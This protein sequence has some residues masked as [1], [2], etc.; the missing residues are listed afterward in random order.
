MPRNLPHYTKCAPPG[1][2]RPMDTF[3]ILGLSLSSIII[4]GIGGTA[5]AMIM[6]ILGLA[7][8][9]GCALG[10]GFI[11]FAIYA[12]FAFKHWYYNERLLCIK[13]D[14]CV[15][16]TVVHDPTDATDGDR[17][18]DIVLAPFS[19]DEQV[20]W[21]KEVIEDKRIGGLSAP[22][23]SE[24][25]DPNKFKDF[26]SGAPPYNLT[27]SNLT[28]IYQTLVHEKI[29]DPSH[30]DRNFY[31]HYFRTEDPP[32]NDEN[33]ATSSAIPDD[34]YNPTGTSNPMFRYPSGGSDTINEVGDPY[35][36]LHCEMEGYRLGAWLDNVAVGLIAGGTTFTALC[37]LCEVIT[38]GALD[39]LCGW[40]GGVISIILAFLAWLISHF[41]N[42]PDD[43]VAESV[44]VDVDENGFGSPSTTA[45]KGDI[46]AIFGNWIMDM[47]HLNYFEIHP[48]K[49]WYLI[50]RDPRSINEFVVTETQVASNCDF[51]V[52]QLTGEDADEICRIITEAET[53]DPDGRLNVTVKA[54]LSM[55]GGTRN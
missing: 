25:N 19:P 28:N 38:F 33:A 49:A 24:L 52:N 30:A 21:L 39:F 51:D 3:S 17:K 42:D 31:S 22:T 54:S 14:M 18:F 53:H 9:L 5:Y 37:V 1:V 36:Y 43:H 6:S 20:A 29:L 2:A 16:G 40:L 26:I 32:V 8:G 27:K 46:V 48:V 23:P 12:L 47:E 7:A 4:G 55:I 11:T 44:D 34:A 50:C 10:V 45:R 13:H 35:V 15:I 41:V